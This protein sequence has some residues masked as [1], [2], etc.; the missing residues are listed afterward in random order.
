MEHSIHGG[1]FNQILAINQ[2][3]I[4]SIDSR[5]IFSFCLVFDILLT[6]ITDKDWTRALKKNVP[7]RKGWVIKPTGSKLN[8][9]FLQIYSNFH[10]LDSVTDKPE[11]LSAID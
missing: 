11:T 2:G 8:H 3:K 1:S 9:F 4:C 10:N 6:Y 7:E 5:N